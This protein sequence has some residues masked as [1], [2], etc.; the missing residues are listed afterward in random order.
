MLPLVPFIA[1]V[2]T[3]VAAVRILRNRTTRE[4]LD[5]AQE[6]LSEGASRVARKAKSSTVAGLKSVEKTAKAMRNRL[7]EQELVDTVEQAVDEVAE[8]ERVAEDLKRARPPRSKAAT[9]RNTARSP[10]QTSAKTARKSVRRSTKADRTSSSGEPTD[11]A[12]TTSRPESG[13]TS[14]DH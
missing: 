2:L 1:G 4:K 3:G 5:R 10:R 8:V 7:D 9:S 12:Q 13:Q 11:K 6:K 14:A